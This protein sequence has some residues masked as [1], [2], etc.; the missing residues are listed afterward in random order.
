MFHKQVWAFYW[1]IKPGGQA[2]C[3]YNPIKHDSRVHSMASKTFHKKRVSWEFKQGFKLWGEDI[4]IQEKQAMPHQYSLH[5]E[6]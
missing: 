5:K 3:L 1:G 2:E 4:S 6:Y